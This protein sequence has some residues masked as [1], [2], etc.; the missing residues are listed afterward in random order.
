MADYVAEFLG[1]LVLVA[2]G[3][4]VVATAVVGL[5]ESGRTSV[6]FQSGSDWLLIAFGWGMAVA[7]AVY[8]A[9]GVSGAHLN[10]AVTLAWAIKRDFPWRKVPGYIAAQVAG[11]F[12]GA[13]L[14]YAVN[15]QAIAAHEA[16]E[17]ITRAGGATVGIFVTGPAPY[18]VNYVGP[19]LVEVVGTAFLVLF[20]LALTDLS[21]TP[22]RANLSPL[23]IGMAV[24]A[25]GVSF[26]ANTGYALNPARDF[27]PRV[28]AWLAGWDRAAFPGTEAR[29]AAYWW[30]PLVAPPIG[31]ILGAVVYDRGIASVLQVRQQH[32]SSGASRRGTVIEED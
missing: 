4:G 9:G 7:F 26:G 3:T 15:Y 11:A 1:T 22:V 30:V 5:P 10:P 2:L 19:V 23:M 13:A 28:L 12:A 31:G 27:G 16:R 32:Q 6:A 17:G 21:N 20:I 29:L 8:V 14:V 24:F 25:I 18:Y